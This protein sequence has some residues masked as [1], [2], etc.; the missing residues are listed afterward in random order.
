MNHT[1]EDATVKRFHYDS[2]DQLRQHL[3]DFVAAYNFACRHKTPCGLTPHEAICK[4]WADEPSR[5]TQNPR[6][7]I[8]GPII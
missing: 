1:I 8:L 3:A 7:Q 6:H 5:F 2:H 4:A